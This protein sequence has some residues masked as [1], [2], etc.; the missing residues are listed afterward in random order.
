[1]AEDA[2]FN[3]ISTTQQTNHQVKA[4]TTLTRQGALRHLRW[5]LVALS[6]R[7]AHLPETKNGES[8]TVPLS[9]TAASVLRTLPRAL[10]DVVF[11]SN[12]IAAAAP[13][14]HRHPHSDA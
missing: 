7:T 13:N 8:R 2:G 4:P 1:M 10:H 9:T 5:E 3:P 11:L 12:R 14:G 6:R